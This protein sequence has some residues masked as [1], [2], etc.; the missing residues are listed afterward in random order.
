[1]KKI[2]L[3]AAL[4]VMS[5]LAL[6]LVACG[7][8]GGTVTG[9]TASTSVQ[10]DRAFTVAELAQYDGTNG[11]PAYVAVDGVVYDVSASKYWTDGVHSNCPL[12][13]VAG[14]DLSAL[15]NQAPPTM[16]SQLERMPVVG[17]LG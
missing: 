14:K 4:A 15:I 5:V 8:G 9:D 7:G 12:G 3:V 10:A 6:A 2:A 1:M 16:R 11:Q 17:H 13:A